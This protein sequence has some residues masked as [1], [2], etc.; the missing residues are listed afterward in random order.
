[1]TEITKS[2]SIENNMS[3][4]DRCVDS[5]LEYPL[6]LNKEFGH[7]GRLMYNN[8]KGNVGMPS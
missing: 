5:E 7:S 6:K 1:M 4:V 2:C 3:S 8:I